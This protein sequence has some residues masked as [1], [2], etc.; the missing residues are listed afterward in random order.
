LGFFNLNK[1]KTKRR[2]ECVGGT[3][4][5]NVAGY[6]IYPGKG[7]AWFP[8][9]ELMAHATAHALIFKSSTKSILNL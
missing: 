6:C 3:L 1:L 9:L 4:N 2:L 5:T 7:C 8:S